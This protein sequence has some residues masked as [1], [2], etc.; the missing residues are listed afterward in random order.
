MP[1]PADLGSLYQTRHYFLLPPAGWDTAG[2]QLMF[3]N[4]DDKIITLSVTGIL[5]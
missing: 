5:I 4:T 3:L 2:I 1:P